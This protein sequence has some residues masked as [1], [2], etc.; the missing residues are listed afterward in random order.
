[1]YYTSQ[2]E[3]GM[4]KNYATTVDKLYRYYSNNFKNV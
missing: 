1:M 2:K 4:E 3:Q